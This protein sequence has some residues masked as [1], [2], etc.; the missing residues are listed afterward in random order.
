MIP[1]SYLFKNLYHQTWENPDV[2]V[3]RESQPRLPGGLMRPLTAAIAAI[4]S[5]SKMNNAPHLG[6]HAY[7]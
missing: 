7:E 1:A 6:A 2:P 5:R 3:A 4:F